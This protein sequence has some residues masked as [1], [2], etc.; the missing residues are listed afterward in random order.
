MKKQKKIF[1]HDNIN[2][3]NN[4]YCASISYSSA[5]HKLKK[6][7]IKKYSFIKNNQEII[8]IYE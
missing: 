3:S 8:I 4:K 7:E 6:F 5:P 2:C 1:Y